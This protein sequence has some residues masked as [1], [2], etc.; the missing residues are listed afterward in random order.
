MLQDLRDNSKG[1]I[2]KVIIGAIA[3]IFVITGWETVGGLIQA[4]PVAEINGEEITQ[5]QLDQSTQNL[6]NSVGGGLEGIDQGF[7][8]SIALNQLIEEI[9]LRQHVLKSSMAISSSQIDRNILETPSFQVNGVFD[10]DF[11]V[12]TILSQTGQNVPMY[13]ESLEQRMLLSQ[14]ASAYTSSNFI[15]ESELDKI[16]QLTTQTRDFRYISIT[17]GTRT[18]GTAISDGEIAVYYENNQDAFGEDETIIARYV[19]LDKDIISQELSVDEADLIAQYEEERSQYEGSS[20]RRASHILFEVGGDLTESAALELATT[21]QQRITDGEEFASLALEL[22]SDTVS[23]EEGGDI[24]YTDGSAFPPELE[25]ALSALSLDEISDPVVS[26]FGVHLVKLTEDAENVFASFEEVRDRIERDLK[27]SEVE[28]IY[29]ERLQDL[30]NLAFE[31]GDLQTISEELNL[32]IRQSEAFGRLGGNGIFSNQNVA[33]AAYSDDVLLEGNN[34]DVIEINDSQSVVLRLFEFNEAS[35][36]PLEEVQPEIAVILRTEMEEDAVQELGSEINAAAISGVGLDQILGD[37]ELEWIEEVQLD[38]N[39]FT[40]NR[41]ILDQ[42]FA[43][44]KPSIGSVERASL[45]LDNG[46]F[47]LVELTEVNEGTVDSIPEEE[48]NTMVD[49]M[50]ADLGNSEFQAFMSTLKSDSDI[51]NNLENLEL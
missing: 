24:G 46:T 42:A 3:S 43:L 28:L 49:S 5:L 50:I 17:L 41:Q 40:V 15:T 8:E 36:L 23:A 30:S 18:L 34:S 29:A 1:L 14:V 20:E 9:I 21:A 11:A 51:Q 44:S 47:V 12:R 35:I 16:A 10:P 37:N 13:R 19:L 31:T 4:P 6:V 2:A 27:S 39:A 48:R 38:R 32:N 45:T 22:S 25:E 26:E 7:L 33:S